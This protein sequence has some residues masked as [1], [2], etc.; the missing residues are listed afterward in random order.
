MNISVMLWIWAGLA[1]L[2]VVAAALIVVAEVRIA[3][4]D[5]RELAQFCKSEH[6][7]TSAQVTPSRRT[8]Q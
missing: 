8:S 6:T 2:S 4:P 1:V 5:T 3:D 7:S